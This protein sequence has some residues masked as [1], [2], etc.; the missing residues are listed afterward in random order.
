M[1]VRPEGANHP[2]GGSRAHEPQDRGEAHA[3]EVAAQDAANQRPAGSHGRGRPLEKGKERPDLHA[4]VLAC[5]LIKEI[6]LSSRSLF[7]ANLATPHRR[8]LP[9]LPRNGL[10]Q[11]SQPGIA[12]LPPRPGAIGISQITANMTHHTNVR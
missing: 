2:T 10:L 5:E 11:L 12:T 1:A 6:R 4:R 3:R 9:R 8:Q 7:P